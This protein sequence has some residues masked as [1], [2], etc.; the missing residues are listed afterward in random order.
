MELFL[1]IIIA[2]LVY[3]TCWTIPDAIK[4]WRS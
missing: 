4:N 3:V 1:A 2:T